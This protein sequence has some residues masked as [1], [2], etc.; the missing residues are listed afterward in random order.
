MGVPNLQQGVHDK[1]GFINIPKKLHLWRFCK[2]K[3]GVQRR[4]SYAIDD[5]AMC[6]LR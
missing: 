2:C 5:V 3:M 1:S 6:Y 4:S